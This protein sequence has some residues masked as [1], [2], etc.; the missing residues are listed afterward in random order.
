MVKAASARHP[1]QAMG[2]L[3]QNN[4]TGL[5]WYVKDR[6]RRGLPVDANNIVLDDLHHGHMAYEAYVQNRDK[7]E[8]IKALEKRCDKYNFND[9]D[10]KVTKTL[11]LVYGRNY[12]PI[13]YVIW[14]DKPA[15]WNPA[16]DAVNDYKQLM[17]Q[18]P[19]N[20]IAFEQ[21]NETV[22]S[23]IQLAVVHSQAET[24]IYDHVPGR[25]G[26][27]AMQALHNHYEGEA[28]LDV[29]AL[30]AQQ[31]MDTLVYTN[32]KQMTF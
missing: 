12:C 32:K 16:V 15:G 21:D 22:F 30:K 7:G 29:Q 17:Y 27:G 10:R 13:A 26:S 5:I 11:S 19:L 23:F 25:D 28:E 14:S 18:L 31:I 9:W 6:T 4:L 2:I 1:A 8:N 24:W 20:G 3:I